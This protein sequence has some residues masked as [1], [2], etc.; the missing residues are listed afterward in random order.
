MSDTFTMDDAKQML[1]KILASTTDLQK[2]MVT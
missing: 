2:H 1:K